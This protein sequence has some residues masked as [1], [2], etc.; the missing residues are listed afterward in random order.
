MIKTKMSTVLSQKALSNMLVESSIDAIIAISN[1][2]D[3]IAWN[4]A[5]AIIYGRQKED[6]LGK[7]LYKILPSLEEDEE[8]GR[9]ITI[10]A[11]GFKSFVPAA[12][13][14]EHRRHTEIHII[15][16]KE[17]KEVTG[18]MLL[19]H[20]VSHRIKAEESLQYLNS[21]LQDRIRQLQATSRELTYLTHIA[22]HKIRGPIRNIYTA[23][24]GLIKT[25]AAHLSNSGR[26]SF[27]RMQS[28]L[29]RMNLLLDDII[30]L[31]EINILEKPQSLVRM[32]EVIN[33]VVESL[34]QRIAEKNAVITNHELCEIRAHKNQLV[35]LL[36][37]MLHNAIKFNHSEVPHISI[38]CC[39]VNVEKSEFETAKPGE[40][41]S[42]TIRHNGMSSAQTATDEMQGVV[43]KLTENIDKGNSMTLAIATKIMEAHGG[44]LVQD[45]NTDKE[46]ILKCFFP[47]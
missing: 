5:A 27:R 3:I 26:A 38:A 17:F 8:I 21:E 34:E 23:I 39:K 10:A 15:P 44:F 20:D 42:L 47:V 18:I 41:Y 1:N 11:K 12:K 46:T 35:L 9:A 19:V 2:M 4:A 31:T 22:T 40:Y 24:E 16:L 37:Q 30:T 45:N 6:V 13:E 29:N 14:F 28:S 36:H 32:D 33:E 43:D 25:E 7:Q